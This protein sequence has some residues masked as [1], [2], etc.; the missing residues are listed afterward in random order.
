MYCVKL[1]LIKIVQP[2]FLASHFEAPR[3]IASKSQK[4]HGN[5]HSAKFHADQSLRCRAIRN[6]TK[7][8]R[9]KKRKQETKKQN[10]KQQTASFHT[11]V[12]RVSIIITDIVITA[13]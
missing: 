8:G 2:S 9:K 3:V 6:W 11:I 1:R 7:N 12:W 4:T 13:L 5:D 10:K